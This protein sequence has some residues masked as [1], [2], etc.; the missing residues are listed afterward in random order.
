MTFNMI[1]NSYPKVVDP[2][3]RYLVLD[4]VEGGVVA[5]TVLL[6]HEV[7]E[8]GHPGQLVQVRRGE[9]LGLQDQR[10]LELPLRDLHGSPHVL[11]PVAGTEPLP[12][13]HEAGPAVVQQGGQVDPVVPV[14]GEVLDVAVRQYGLQ[15]ERGDRYLHIL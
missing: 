6:L 1:L 11:P 15:R 3:V 8:V 12:V 9:V 13:G 10:D 5:R 7:G 14:G 4:P 2:E